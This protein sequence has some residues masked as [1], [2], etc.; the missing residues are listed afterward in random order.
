MNFFL[1]Q[2][3]RRR[4]RGW[5]GAAQKEAGEAQGWRAIPASSSAKALLSS[6]PW[7][8]ASWSGCQSPPL[9]ATRTWPSKHSVT[10]PRCTRCRWA[11]STHVCRSFSVSG[12]HP[13]WLSAWQTLL[14]GP[15]PRSLPDPALLLSHPLALGPFPQHQGDL[16]A[17]LTALQALPPLSPQCPP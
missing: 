11:A 14:K 4:L 13:A 3:R 1:S 9:P 15:L 16:S 7:L 5:N 6:L 8:A 10:R 17:F 12:P 2:E